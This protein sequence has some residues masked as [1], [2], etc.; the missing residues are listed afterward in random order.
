M[1]IATCI[2]FKAFLT[3]MMYT[4]GK[5]LWKQSKTFFKCFTDFGLAF[6]CCHC[7]RISPSPFLQIHYLH[8]V[9]W[10]AGNYVWFLSLH[11]FACLSLNYHTVPTVPV[12][13]KQLK[14]CRALAA[15]LGGAPMGTTRFLWCA[16][17]ADGGCLG[18]PVV[19]LYAEMNWHALL[20]Q[21]SKEA[22]ERERERERERGNLHLAGLIQ[23]SGC[24]VPGCYL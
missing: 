1:G 19:H 12:K 4:A 14:G 22:R 2:E 5:I 9:L 20:E 3:T 18:F 24:S 16:S 13:V 11:M 15:M 17:T 6:S 10:Q 7:R 23:T 8:A 21:P